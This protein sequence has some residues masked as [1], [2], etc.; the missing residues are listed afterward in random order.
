[1]NLTN[2]ILKRRSEL[3]LSRPLFVWE[4]V[5]DSCTSDELS[6]VLDAL[7]YID[8]VSPNHQELAALTKQGNSDYSK[9][10]VVRGSSQLMDGFPNRKGAVI[11]RCGEHGCYIASDGFNGSLPAYHQP[12]ASE[13][14]RVVDPTGAGNAFLGALCIGMLDAPSLG[15][16]PYLCGSIYGSIAAGCA[17]EQIGFP[18]LTSEDNELWNGVSMRERRQHYDSLLQDIGL[19]GWRT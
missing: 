6:N 2:G 13:K 16:D 5:P 10:P 3:G 11:V 14:S 17:V 18:R 7:R 8:V 19:S 9:Q 12:E 4:P 1:V 15:V